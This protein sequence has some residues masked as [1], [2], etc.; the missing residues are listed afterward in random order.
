MKELSFYVD[1]SGDFG[2][3]DY[4]APFYIISFILHNHEVDI[5]EDVAK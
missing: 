1:E 4:N 2:E 3:Y 5:S